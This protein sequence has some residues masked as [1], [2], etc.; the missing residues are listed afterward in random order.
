M[1][2]P[3]AAALL[4]VVVGPAR[5]WPGVRALAVDAQ[6]AALG[7]AWA[8]C[9]PESV[10]AAVLDRLHVIDQPTIVVLAADS[11]EIDRLVGILPI[12]QFRAELTRILDGRETLEAL[13]AVATRR[14]DDLGFQSTL[15]LKLAERGD[16]RAH[17]ILRQVLRAGADRRGATSRAAWEG[18]ATLARH[19]RDDAGIVAALESLRTTTPG[20]PAWRP[21]LWAVLARAYLHLGDSTGALAT[22]SRALA[23]APDDTARVRRAVS[24][25]RLWNVGEDSVRVWERRTSGTTRG[26]R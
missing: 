17:G 14:P 2:R 21:A 10:G 3:S 26:G 25:C 4:L 8:W 11:S 19:Q 24:M 22:W 7:V 6:V 23:A 12:E 13:L 5:T 9:D 16:P 1:S 15:G 20:E 18:L